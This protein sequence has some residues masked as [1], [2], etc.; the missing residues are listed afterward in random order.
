MRY[1]FHQALTPTDKAALKELKSQLSNS[2]VD[3]QAVES[4]IGSMSD[5]LRPANIIWRSDGMLNTV[6]LTEELKPIARAATLAKLKKQVPAANKRM[7]KSIGSK[8]ARLDTKTLQE[9]NKLL[10]PLN[11]S[12]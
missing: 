6:Y 11:R 10:A 2:Q 1:K 12:V 4:L 7:I 8:L 3:R 5:R 9:M